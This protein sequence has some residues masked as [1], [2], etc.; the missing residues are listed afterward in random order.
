MPRTL[1]VEE[2]LNPSDF[3][4]KFY[5]KHSLKKWIR[6]WNQFREMAFYSYS[7]FDGDEG[8]YLE[9]FNYFLKLTEAC[10]LIHSRYSPI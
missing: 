6:R 10:Y 5:L 3:L 1:S 8:E 2:V 4:R 7:I 9:D